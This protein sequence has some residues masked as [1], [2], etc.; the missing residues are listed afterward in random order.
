MR[1]FKYLFKNLNWIERS[2]DFLH[3]FEWTVF[4]ALTDDTGALHIYTCWLNAN[5]DS[6][7]GY[8]SS[9]VAEQMLGDSSAAVD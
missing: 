3:S 4:S 9:W 1:I 5:W 2:E 7:F 8:L 6:G